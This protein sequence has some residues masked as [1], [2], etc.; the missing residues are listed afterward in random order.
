MPIHAVS[1]MDDRIDRRVSRW[2]V[3][4]F[5]PAD[6]HPY[7]R[8]TS[9]WIRLIVAVAVVAWLATG[10]DQVGDVEHTVFE[11]FNQLPDSLDDLFRLLYGLG[12]LWGLG[13][14]VVAALIGRRWRLARDLVLAGLLAAALA[15]SIGVFVD[16]DSASEAVQATV[17]L[18]SSSPAFPA[19]RLAV[20]VAVVAAAAPY[21]T[22]PTRRTGRLFA[23]VM[24]LAAMYLGVALPDAVVAGAVLGWGCGALVHL[25]FGSPGGRPTLPQMRASLAEL[26]VDVDDLELA[27]V[28]PDDATLMT[29][30]TEDGPLRIRVLGR[31]EADAQALGRIWRSIVFKSPPGRLHLTRIEAVEHEAYAVLLAAQAG[32]R[33]PEVV[34]TGTAG[35]GAAVYV[36]HPVDGRPLS[37]LGADELTENRLEQLWRQVDALHGAGVVHLDLTLDHVVLTGDGDIALT[38]FGSA[39]VGDRHD[40]RLHD[41]ATLLVATSEVVGADRAVAAAAFGIGRERLAA[42]LPVLQSAVLPSALRPGSRS[43]R[44]AFTDRLSVL[45]STAA[46]A[47]EVEPPRLTE[48]H[49]ISGATLAM[50]IGTFLGVAALLSQV[51]DPQELWDTMAAADW[52]WVSLAIV[53][54]LLTNFSTAM[55]LMGSVPIRIPLLR[56]AELQLSL[57]FANLAVPTVGGLASQVRYLQKQGVDLA[58]AVAAG[59]VVSGVANVVVTS[60]VCLLA[61]LLSPAKITTEPIEPNQLLGL[62]LIAAVIIGAVCGIVFGVPRIRAHVLAPVRNA[63]AIVSSAL[64]SPRQLGQLVFGWAANALMYAFVLYCCVAAFGPPVNFWTI[65]LINTGVSTLAFAVPVPGGATAVS[66]VGVAGLLTAVG[67]SQEVAVAASLAYQVT[68]TFIPAVPGWFCFRN[69]MAHDFL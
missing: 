60:S 15:R 49:R 5:G 35:P 69:L 48:M 7:R 59:G 38:S 3:Q 51:G 36:E 8:R 11:A 14:V 18:G 23:V 45:R 39:T 68:A 17:R 52:E 22:R 9:D 25:L 16:G 43:E 10:A 42:V 64:R 6:E 1:Q 26:G 4:T 61:I 13:L 24:S 12:T 34:V 56:T 58:G 2:R 65:V 30:S 21:V 54:S 32:V 20:I 31:D 47:V 28:Q 27:P 40:Y 41:V 46:A 57:S 67:A 44:S 53:V 62:L 66:S 50:V 33:T 63:W 55:A 37:G 19:T 29:A